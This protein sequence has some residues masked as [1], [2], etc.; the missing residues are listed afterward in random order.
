MKYAYSPHTGEFINTP[1]PADWMLT[2][3]IAPPSFNAMTS[4]CFFR[5]SAWEVVVAV[6]DKISNP[7]IA[8]ID[9]Q[10]AALDARKIRP[11]AEGDTAYLATLNAQTLVLRAKRAA[12][13]LLV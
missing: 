1:T 7:A 10:L 6:P 8:A 5:N 13:P 12:L 3:T 2:T 9:A 4:G 11:M